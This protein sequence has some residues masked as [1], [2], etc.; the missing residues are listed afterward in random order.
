MNR[1]ITMNAT[2]REGVDSVANAP[3]NQTI[4]EYF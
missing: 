4:W 3:S 1:H 2:P